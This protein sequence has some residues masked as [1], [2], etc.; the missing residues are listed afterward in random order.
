MAPRF[1]SPLHLSA[2]VGPLNNIGDDL[3]VNPR[4]LLNPN[5][6]PMLIDQFRFAF[7]DLADVEGETPSF[8]FLSVLACEIRL[9]AVPLMPKPVT[10]GSFVPRYVGSL[11]AG[12]YSGNPYS[13]VAASP[14]SSDTIFVWHLDKPLFVPQDVQLTVRLVRQRLFANGSMPEP[15]RTFPEV[16]V[17]V[18]GR[19]LPENEPNPP[20]IWVPWVT[21]TK[22]SVDE[23]SFTSGD[24]DIVNSNAEPLHV[25]AFASINYRH[26]I[27]GE[28]G[29]YGPTFGDLRVQMT[30]SN[31]TAFV[32]DPV[33]Y[34]LLFPV[35]RGLLPVDAILQPGQFMRCG[36]EI[37]ETPALWDSYDKV[38][39]FTSVGMVG[40]R[41]IQTPRNNQ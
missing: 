40:Y 32:R 41:S 4:N 6:G 12:I 7:S 21:E 10:L 11:Y 18:V 9:G 31:G 17:S 1:Y 37:A 25:K 15:T 23:P 27:S 2:T 29:V 39:Q 30:A 3:V 16:R 24:A 38:V 5:R 35:D 34:K 28:I 26:A 8:T 20:R 13:N 36:I 33:P 19:S 14:L 22:A